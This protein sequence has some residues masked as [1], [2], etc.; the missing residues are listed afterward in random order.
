[1]RRYSPR[2]P[3]GIRGCVQQP[4]QGGRRD[5]S[6]SRQEKN[7]SAKKH[8]NV[9]RIRESAAVSPDPNAWAARIA[10]PKVNP[11]MAVT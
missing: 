10:S 7:D 4:Q 2:Q 8:E 5:N 3:N 9:D 11:V 6:H 1:M